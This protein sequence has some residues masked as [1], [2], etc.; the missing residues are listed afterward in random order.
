MS[1]T[2]LLAPDAIFLLKILETIS[3]FEFVHAIVSLSSYIFLSAGTNSLLCEAI[4]IL[5]LFIRN[6]NSMY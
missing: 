2:I 5:F 1:I 3:G 4:T 6:N